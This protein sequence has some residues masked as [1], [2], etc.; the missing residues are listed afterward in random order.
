MDGKAQI[1]HLQTTCHLRAYQSEALTAVR[2]AYKAG[3]RRVIVS[4]PTG[5]GKTVVFAHFPGIGQLANRVTFQKPP[6]SEAAACWTV[7]SRRIYVSNFAPKISC[8][9]KECR[10][11]CR[12]RRS[13]LR[14]SLKDGNGTGWWVSGHDLYQMAWQ[15]F[16]QDPS[17][18]GKLSGLAVVGRLLDERRATDLRHISSSHLIFRYN[19]HIV[20]STFSPFAE[21]A[22]ARQLHDRS[23]PKEIQIDGEQ[24]LASSVD[25]TP[26]KNSVVTLTVLKSDREA[27][28]FLARLNRLLLGT[29]L[30]AV[31]AGATLVL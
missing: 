22:L 11:P 2:D 25:L 23:A 30:L 16:Y 18:K 15:P 28:G 27:R 3:K 17:G 29:G 5:T 12:R 26:G 1:R 7:H 24:F 14:R 13:N 19:G 4:L 20:L 31:L 10:F 8:T 21:P 6:A 9:Y